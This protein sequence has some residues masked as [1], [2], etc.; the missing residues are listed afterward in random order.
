MSVGS[1]SAE[2]NCQLYCAGGQNLGLVQGWSRGIFWA[3]CKDLGPGVTTMSSFI[4][5]LERLLP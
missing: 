3:G 5:R 2:I 4:S 1:A